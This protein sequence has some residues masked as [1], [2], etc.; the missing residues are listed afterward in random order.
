MQRQFAKLLYLLLIFLGVSVSASADERPSKGTIAVIG[1]GDMGDSFGPRLAGLGYK[2]IYGSR[3]PD[4]DRVRTLL[5]HTGHGATAASSDEAIEK[6]DIVLFAVPWQ[7]IQGLTEN[8]ELYAGKT[9]IDITWPESIVADDGY[10]Q[11]VGSISGAE[12]IQARL[13]QAMVVKAFGTLGS[14]MIDNPND[15]G[16]L[17]SVPIASDHREAKE[18]T[19][20]IAAELGFDPVDAGPL[21]FARNIE[22]MME[23]YLVPHFQ[24]RKAGWEFYFRRTNYWMCHEYSGDEFYDYGPEIADAGDLADMP[25][26]QS[27]PGSCD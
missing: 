17:V 12:I 4:S 13:P 14:Q 22:A 23:L 24:G 3:S 8:H 20:R 27:E 7:A 16:G 9:V 25:T 1:T 18:V 2:V 19:G 5:Q 10:E 26:P 15:A 6:A 21:R 11:M